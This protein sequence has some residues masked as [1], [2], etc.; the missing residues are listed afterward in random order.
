MV[1]SVVSGMPIV[2][3]GFKPRPGQKFGSRFLLR[4]HFIANL[5]MMITLT[6]HCLWEDVMARERTGRLPS[7]AM[8]KKMK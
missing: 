3:F 6:A 7:Y 2:R 5:A 8:A 1:Q 4:L